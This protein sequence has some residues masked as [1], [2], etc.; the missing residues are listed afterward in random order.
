MNTVD[1]LLWVAFPYA[2]SAVFILGHIYR[3]R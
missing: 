2:A 1:I 3:Y